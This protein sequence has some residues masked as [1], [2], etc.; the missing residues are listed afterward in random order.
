MAGRADVDM[1]IDLVTDYYQVNIIC[2][3]IVETRKANDPAFDTTKILNQL[4]ADDAWLEQVRINI[5]L[6]FL[7][8][9]TAIT[10]NMSVDRQ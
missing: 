2:S 6:Y 10:K 7:T 5:F 3:V 1:L 4:L 8:R 9:P